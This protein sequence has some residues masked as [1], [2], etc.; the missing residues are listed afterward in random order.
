[1]TQYGH[2][3]EQ[4]TQEPENNRPTLFRTITGIIMVAIYMGMAF[5]LVFTNLFAYTVPAWIRYMMGGVFFL[6]G[7]YRG[8]RVYTGRR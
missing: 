2:Y 1:M 3:D 6:Y 8:Y 5:L 4:P 7:I